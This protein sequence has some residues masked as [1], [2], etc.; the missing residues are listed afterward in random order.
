MVKFNLE[1][2][3]A[4]VVLEVP[5]EGS[6]STADTERC[7][8]RQLLREL[9]DEGLTDATVNGHELKR[10]GAGSEHGLTP[11]SHV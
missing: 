11:R 10:P 3:Q 7:S 8:M 9:E 2:D 6:K 4:P 1:N 5:E